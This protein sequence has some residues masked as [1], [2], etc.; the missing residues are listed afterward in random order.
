MRAYKGAAGND[1]AVEKET[2]ETFVLLGVWE[3]LDSR[4]R[5]TIEL[6]DKGIEGGDARKLLNRLEKERRQVE[7]F[8]SR[9]IVRED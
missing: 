4:V 8:L 6:R 2:I 3:Q 5:A 9:L 1:R 7:D